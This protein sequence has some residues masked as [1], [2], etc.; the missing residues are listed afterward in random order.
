MARIADYGGLQTA[1]AEWLWRTGDASVEGRADAFI[2]FFEKKFMRTQRTR[3]MEE[4]DTA[5][6][7]GASMTLPA[8]YLE[9]IRLR[10]STTNTPLDYVT[11]AAAAVLDANVTSQSSGIARHYTVLAG[12]IIILPQAWAPTDQTLEM[13]FYAFTQLADAEGGTN[14]L[15]QDHPDIYLYGSLMQAAAYID[16]K[17]TVAFWKAGLDEAMDELLKADNKSKVGAAPLVQ[18]PSMGFR[19]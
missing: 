5:T 1:V 13:A 7:G 11:P 17:E 15:L 3:Q 4:V 14:W 2:D 10:V 19:Q 6:V 18:R 12:N 9:M 8:G 16:D